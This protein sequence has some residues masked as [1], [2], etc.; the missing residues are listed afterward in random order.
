MSCIT[1]TFHKVD[2]MLWY[3]V[4]SILREIATVRIEQ[5]HGDFVFSLDDEQVDLIILFINQ[6][7]LGYLHPN[8]CSQ[9]ILLS[10]MGT[11][12][13]RS[14]V[15]KPS[16]QAKNLTANPS[17]KKNLKQRKEVVAV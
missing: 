3:S 2:P 13:M 16:Q 14:V 17:T 5:G 1:Q 10:R 8:S 15:V 9:T 7:Q 12:L 6:M 11:K 4:E